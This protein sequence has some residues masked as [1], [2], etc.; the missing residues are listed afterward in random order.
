M[1]TV[2]GREPAVWVALLTAALGA[3]TAFGWN[4]SPTTQ[5]VVIA[6]ASAVLG[7]VVAITV[8]DGIVA[9]VMG[10][11]QALVSLV[12]GMGY[13]LSADNQYKIMLFV[14]AAATWYTRSQVTAPVPA[15]ASPAGKLVA[16]T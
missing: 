1:K 5:A 6:V 8:H 2:L 16:K 12:V 14:A 9:A 7:L 15:S 11:S 10:L 13:D 3:A 4:V